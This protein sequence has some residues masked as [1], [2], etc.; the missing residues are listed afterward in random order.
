[1]GTKLSTYK[2]TPCVLN[3]GK[4]TRL[5]ILKTQGGNLRRGSISSD[6]FAR[7]HFHNA[8]RSNRF[9]F[10]TIGIRDVDFIV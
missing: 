7:G 6:G 4:S 8:R 3:L 2:T 1:M 5:R 10:E 9:P